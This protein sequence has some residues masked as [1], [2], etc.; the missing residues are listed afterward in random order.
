MTIPA[1]VNRVELDHPL[2]D[3][4]AVFG[5]GGKSTL[6]AVIA[7]KA[8]PTHIDLDDVRLLPDCVE[9]SGAE[10]LDDVRDMMSENLRGW[11][12]DHRYLQAMEGAGSVVVLALPFRT[13]LWRRFKRPVKR[14]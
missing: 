10:G 2:G 5:I 14:S 13:M 6:A 7:R 9:R 8:D 3:R 1:G 12:T 4:V 11:V